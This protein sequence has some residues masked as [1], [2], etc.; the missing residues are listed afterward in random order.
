[1]FFSFF[2]DTVYVSQIINRI[3]WNS[4]S[5]YLLVQYVQFLTVIC[6]FSILCIN[7]RSLYILSYIHIYIY[8]WQRLWALMNQLFDLT[9]T[10]C[11]CFEI[12]KFLFLGNAFTSRS[13]ILSWIIPYMIKIISGT[14]SLV[15]VYRNRNLL[16]LY[17]KLLEMLKK[18]L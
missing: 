12:L 4:R 14:I 3:L 13:M 16:S 2:P 11:L 5:N 7:H 18:L 15:N 10:W 8:F 1:M 9:K 17:W 6:W